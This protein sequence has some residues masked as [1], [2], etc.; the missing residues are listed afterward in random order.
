M[1]EVITIPIKDV[2]VRNP[3]VKLES[4]DQVVNHVRLRTGL[5]Q[6]TL[7]AI[8][9]H[10]KPNSLS[11]DGWHK[12]TRKNGYLS[13][14]KPRDI[15][16]N[17]E[18]TGA[19]FCEF[20]S[21]AMQEA[22]TAIAP[23]LEIDTVAIDTDNH[24]ESWSNPAYY[25]NTG[26]HT[27]VKV[28]EKDTGKTLYIDPTYRQIDH[29]SKEG[30]I[31]FGQDEFDSYYKYSRRAENNRFNPRSNLNRKNSLIKYIERSRGFTQEH[32]QRLVRTITS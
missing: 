15:D 22:L 12:F 24:A 7:A 16:K 28:T 25:L 31:F 10:Q 18:F 8:S 5:F 6:S 23:N 17:A 19:G 32:Y 27:I 30:I 29:R 3:E 21:F 13:K 14:E 20:S 2:L 9:L 1:A 4:V 26:P 11:K